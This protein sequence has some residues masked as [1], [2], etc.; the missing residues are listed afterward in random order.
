MEFKI[1]EFDRIMCFFMHSLVFL[2]QLHFLPFYFKLIY[3]FID[4]LF[5]SLISSY[6]RLIVIN[7]HDL[8]INST[9]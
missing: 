7:K 5:M 8:E 3:L 9:S 1:F 6:S 4:L 2:L